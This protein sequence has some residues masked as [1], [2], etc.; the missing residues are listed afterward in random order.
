MAIKDVRQL[1]KF[2]VNELKEIMIKWRIVGRSKPKAIMIEKIRADK[3][4]PEIKESISVPIREK[5][6]PSQKQVESRKRF[7][8]MVKK[9]NKGKVPRAKK[10][11]SSS[12]FAGGDTPVVKKKSLFSQIDTINENDKKKNKLEEKIEKKIEKVDVKE[13]EK[14]EKNEK[15]EKLKLLLKKI[16]SQVDKVKEKLDIKRIGLADHI[17]DIKKIDK[18]EVFNNE[19]HANFTTEKGTKRAQFCGPGTKVSLRLLRGDRGLTATDKFCVGHDLDYRRASTTKNISKEKRIDMTQ[20]SD[21]KLL[22]DIADDDTDFFINKLK[23]RFAIGLKGWT[24]S[25]GV[26][27]K[28]KFIGENLPKKE[29]TKFEYSA[30]L[31]DIINNIEDGK[32]I[33]KLLA[34]PK[35]AIREFLMD[36][37]SK[38][39]TQKELEALLK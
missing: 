28:D 2:R 14:E 15:K 26:I 9:K 27:A 12:S 8:E 3:N 37:H 35:K 32:I 13:E 38:E 24:E 11:K 5:K 19:Q 36:L 4:W 17:E 33:T 23:I 20:V 6:K 16:F 7:S 1:K 39:I 29:L 25:F 10:M 21:L 18:E 34:K 31:V 22:N 30:A